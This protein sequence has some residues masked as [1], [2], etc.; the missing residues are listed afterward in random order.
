MT[1]ARQ[2]RMSAKAGA[3]DELVAALKELK[4]ALQPLAGFEGAEL[5]QDVNAPDQLVFLERWTSAQAHA[6]ASPFMPKAALSR[7]MALLA[8][9]PGSATY[10]VI[11][12]N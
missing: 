5:M 3:A 11:N 1:I 2:Y 4:T 8:D 6:D 10:E 12:F 7:V 9:R